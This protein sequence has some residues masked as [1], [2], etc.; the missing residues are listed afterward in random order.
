[1]AITITLTEADLLRLQ[2][3]DIDGDAEEALAFLREVVLPPVKAQQSMA[4]R[5]RFDLG[6]GSTP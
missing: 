4:M 2:V 1:M 6:K 3:I 5:N